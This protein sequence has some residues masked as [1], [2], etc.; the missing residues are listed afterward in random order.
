MEGCNRHWDT[1]EEIWRK[2]VVIL[3]SF[4]EER[5]LRRRT[6]TLRPETYAQGAKH[7][8]TQG[9]NS[10][11][12][13]QK[14]IG[15]WQVWGARKDSSVP[16]I[17]EKEGGGTGK[18]NRILMRQ[19]RS[20]CSGGREQFCHEH[21]WWERTGFVGDCHALPYTTSNF[22]LSGRGFQA[23]ETVPSPTSFSPCSRC[24]KLVQNGRL[25]ALDLKADNPGFSFTFATF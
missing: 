22:R 24:L 5:P 19:R 4:S 12:K 25:N 10:R 21:S 16:G 14:L 11:C 15:A 3:D 18:V 9:K 1:G 20:C 23:W 2:E 13:S 8:K 6:F 17:S 7:V